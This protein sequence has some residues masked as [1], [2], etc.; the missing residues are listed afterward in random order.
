MLINSGSTHSFISWSKVVAL[1]ILIH[2][3]KNFYVLIASG[4]TMKCDG[5]CENVK[6]QMGD[7]QLKTHMFFR[8]MGG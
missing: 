7:Y 8:D 1:H 5:H 2:P 4:G 3:I 6:F